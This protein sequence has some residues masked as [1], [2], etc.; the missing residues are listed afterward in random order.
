MNDFQNIIARENKLQ[1]LLVWVRDN[2]DAPDR[3]PILASIEL[4]Q[5]ALHKESLAQQAKVNVERF[6]HD[7]K[8]GVYNDDFLRE[9]ARRLE[10]MV[11]DRLTKRAAAGGAILDPTR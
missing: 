1:E 2:V 5:Q 3:T 8:M 10:A 9:L 11:N 6:I 7:N 4:R